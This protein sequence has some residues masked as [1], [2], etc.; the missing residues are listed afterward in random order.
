MLAFVLAKEHLF[1]LSG[2]ISCSQF[3]FLHER[4][5]VELDLRSRLADRLRLSSLV[6]LVVLRF[7]KLDR[8]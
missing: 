3:L 4:V 2:R 7:R 6:L 1:V 8:V 5:R